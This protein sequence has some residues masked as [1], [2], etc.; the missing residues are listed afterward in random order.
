MAVLGR[1]CMII[2]FAVTLYGVGSAL[3][4][5]QAGR[6]AWADSARRAV[7]ARALALTKES[8]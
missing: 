2:A 3:Y 1:T 8:S 6:R 5:T 4:G 7:Y